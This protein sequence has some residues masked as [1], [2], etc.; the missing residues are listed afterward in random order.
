MSRRIYLHPSPE[1]H[2]QRK[3]LMAGAALLVAL[4]AVG[5]QLRLT[6][7]EAAIDRARNEISLFS[8]HVA[9]GAAQVAPSDEAIDAVKDDAAE[10]AAAFKAGIE[11]QQT[12]SDAA[13]S[14]AASVNSGQS[15]TAT[16]T[17]TDTA[18]S[19]ESTTETQP[20]PT[21]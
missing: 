3:A 18:P 6:F 21:N 13:A 8:Q 20:S 1:L 14:A 19:T 7:S 10:A 4:F 17:T 9:D 11:A 15:T 16:E 5:I 12:L 2:A